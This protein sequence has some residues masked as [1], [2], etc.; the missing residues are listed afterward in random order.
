MFSRNCFLTAIFASALIAAPAFGQSTS[1]TYTRDYVFPP[2]S[3]ANGETAQV[4]VANTA[5]APTNGTA[6]SCTGTISFT[7]GNGAAT[8]NPV[9]FTVPA[10]Q[11]F[12]SS[13]PNNSAN[14]TAI[15]AT[16]QQTLPI[17]VF[18]VQAILANTINLPCSL[19]LSLEIFSSTTHVVLGN[20]TA[21]AGPIPL[22]IIPVLSTTAP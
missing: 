8:G 21:I 20:S 2:L 14:R 15:L 16:V 11:I 17:P 22:E 18:P 9:A 19:V 12:S 10:G 13:F 4:N 7:T 1:A 5:K 3:L 6:A